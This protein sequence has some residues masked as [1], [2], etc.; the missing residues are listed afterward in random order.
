MC[1]I[2]K[3]TTGK[4]AKSIIYI[5]IYTHRAM[6]T[7]LLMY[8]DI[9]YKCDILVKDTMHRYSKDKSYTYCKIIHIHG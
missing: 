5:Y 6:S 2:V 8:D 4:K 9:K 7:C 1:I 3:L